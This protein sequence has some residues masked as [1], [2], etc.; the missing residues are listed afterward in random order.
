M[1]PS[2]SKRLGGISSEPFRIKFAD[3]RL[4]NR[5]VQVGAELH[6]LDV[7]RVRVAVDVRVQVDRLREVDR[8]TQFEISTVSGALIVL[9]F[10][11]RVVHVGVREVHVEGQRQTNGSEHLILEG[12]PEGDAGIDH[13]ST[14]IVVGVV[15]R[16]RAVVI[17]KRIVRRERQ[18][19]GDRVHQ[20]LTGPDVER[21]AIAAFSE[22]WIEAKIAVPL[23]VTGLVD[24]TDSEF[25]VGRFGVESESFA[26]RSARAVGLRKELRVIRNREVVRNRV[27]NRDVRIELLGV[28]ALA[29]AVVL[30]RLPSG[31]WI[32]NRSAVIFLGDG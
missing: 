20:V 9:G 8:A 3:F 19:R 28:V 4:E 17:T 5:P 1:Q 24:L 16:I 13:V 31:K 11:D 22:T 23:E 18:A 6:R 21:K 2:K 7:H 12:W 30:V 29:E 32:G 26:V 27:S 10:G 14:R 15:G 25:Q